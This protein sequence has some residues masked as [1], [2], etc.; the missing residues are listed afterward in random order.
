MKTMLMILAAIIIVGSGAFFFID[1]STGFVLTKNF[2][3]PFKSYA[4]QLSA[5]A[6]IVFVFNL[7]KK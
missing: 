7:R 2:D 5:L 4:I 3:I 6:V 1:M